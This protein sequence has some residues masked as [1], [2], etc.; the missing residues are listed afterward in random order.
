MANRSDYKCLKITLLFFN[1]QAPFSVSFRRAAFKYTFVSELTGSSTTSVHFYHTARCPNREKD[2]SLHSHRPFPRQ[3]LNPRS[4]VLLEELIVALLV[5]NFIDV[6][7]DVSLS[8]SQVTGAYPE[9][10]E[11]ISQSETCID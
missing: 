11:S 7:P 2:S 1:A 10:R 3:T 5:K 6:I 8:C 9:P 4:T